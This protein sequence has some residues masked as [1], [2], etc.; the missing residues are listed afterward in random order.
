MAEVPVKKPSALADQQEA[1]QANKM[2][3]S[4]IIRKTMDMSTHAPVE[5]ILPHKIMVYCKPYDDEVIRSFIK[6]FSHMQKEYPDI[7]VLVDD[8]VL[9]EIEGLL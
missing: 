7:E 3:S 6:L 1:V 4:P 9:P 2:E 5:C 8:W